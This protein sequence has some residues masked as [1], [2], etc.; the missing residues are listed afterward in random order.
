MASPR[1]EARF[2]VITGGPGAG[3]TTL[4]EA[5][6]LAGYAVVEEA[7]RAVIREQVSS[8]GN[9]LPWGDTA[10][11][12]RLML[13]RDAA[14]W[15]AAHDTPALV[16]FDRGIPDIQ[17]YL[18]LIGAPPLPDVDAAVI[19]HRYAPTVFAAPPWP[20]IYA[21]DAERKQDFA[22]AVR[23]FDAM[24]GTYATLGYT[25]IEL[26]RAAV[27]ERVAFLRDRLG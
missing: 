19:A 15:R 7:G 4:I 11:Y 1:A 14:A 2:Y 10:A 26:P 17:G 13:E 3:K 21:Q 6:R 27:A 20:E 23:T 24:C 18:H 8:G 9:A 22:E 16:F 25:L 5:L 12:A